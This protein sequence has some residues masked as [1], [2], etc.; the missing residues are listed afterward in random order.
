MQTALLINK[1]F[2]DDQLFG[3]FSKLNNLHNFE[4][5]KK[6][7]TNSILVFITGSEYAECCRISLSRDKISNIFQNV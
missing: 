4:K 1:Y 3:E 5:L 6:Y 7:E 2:Y